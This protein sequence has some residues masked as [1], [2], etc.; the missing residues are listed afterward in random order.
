MA[1]QRILKLTLNFKDGNALELTGDSAQRVKQAFQRN[2]WLTG[3]E[4]MNITNSDGKNQFIRF[5]C[6]CSYTDGETDIIEIPDR[7]CEQIDCIP[8]YNG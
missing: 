6:L 4:G 5:D 7:E 8:D 1:K 2:P 3:E